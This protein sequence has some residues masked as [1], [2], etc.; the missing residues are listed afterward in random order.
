MLGFASLEAGRPPLR[1]L[2]VRPEAAG[3]LLVRID[4][5][6][7]RGPSALAAVGEPF[8]IGRRLRFAGHRALAG[9]AGEVDHKH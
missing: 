7:R 8:P 2:L 4:R 6:A 3:I 9:T 1:V 5:A